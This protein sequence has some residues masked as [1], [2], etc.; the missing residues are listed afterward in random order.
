VSHSWP[1]LYRCECNL[2]E[3]DPV[4]PED[5]SDLIDPVPAS[6]R[7]SQC[8]KKTKE[9][10]PSDEP[11]ASPVTATPSP[12]KEVEVVGCQD[13]SDCNVATANEFGDTTETPSSCSCKERFFR[14]G[15]NCQV[16]QDCEESSRNN[17]DE[18]PGASECKDL[19]PGFEC[20]CVGENG[21][22]DTP[23]SSAPGTI[24]IDKDECFLGEDNCNRST[25]E[26]VNLVPVNGK[27][28]CVIKTPSPTPLPTLRPTPPRPLVTP[29]PTCVATGETCT[30]TPECCIGFC[31]RGTCY[32]R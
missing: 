14:I 19:T 16:E 9:E 7:P 2:D 20:R 11:S 4:I 30:A 15:A 24:C 1:E 28:K 18:K 8:I 31:I 26:C 6:W 10:V 5:S 13:D 17:C 3:Y 22:Q 25:H 12:V 23:N 29:P 21:W 27:W 32:R